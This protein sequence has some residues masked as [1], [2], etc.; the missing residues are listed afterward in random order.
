MRACQP[1]LRA[2]LEV[3]QPRV[4][5]LL[6]ATAAQ[7]LLGSTF[8]VTRQRGVVEPG[9]DGIATVATV[10]PSSILRA[11]DADRALQLAA[12]VEDLRT[13]AARL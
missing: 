10:H 2:E 9:I 6:G 13:A 1:W 5:V 12:F 7:S 3:V 8:S 11:R 4:L